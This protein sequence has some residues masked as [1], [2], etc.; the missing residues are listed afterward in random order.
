[1]NSSQKKNFLLL[2]LTFLQ[3]ESAG[4]GFAPTF[5]SVRGVR[6]QASSQSQRIYAGTLIQS[7]DAPVKEDDDEEDG[8]I[9]SA[10]VIDIDA[11]V[12]KAKEGV[13]NEDGDDGDGVVDDA[14]ADADA[15]DGEDAGISEDLILEDEEL[16][17]QTLL[18]IEMMQK[19][20]Q[21]AQSR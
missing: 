12:D 4:F 17:E 13:V 3:R 10:G 2:L 20:I 16:D 7:G 5:T 21:F 15:D 18:D 1:M 6:N 9:A 14:D 8:A 11:L 19:A